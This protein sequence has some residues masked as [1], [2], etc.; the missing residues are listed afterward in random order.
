MIIFIYKKWRR[1]KPN[2]NLDE[3]HEDGDAKAGEGE[4]GVDE[5]AAEEEAPLGRRG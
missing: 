5:M 1:R 2:A 4:E 3:R